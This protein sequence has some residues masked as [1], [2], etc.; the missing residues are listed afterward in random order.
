MT[1]LLTMVCQW[2]DN[3]GRF[4]VSDATDD[5]PFYCPSCHAPMRLTKAERK[6]RA[7]SPR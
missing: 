5:T 4:E 6:D 3:R 1:I 2:C 7:T